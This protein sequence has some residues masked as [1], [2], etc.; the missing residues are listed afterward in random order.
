VPLIWLGFSA[1]QL[2]T[3]KRNLVLM[4]FLIFTAAP[5]HRGISQQTHHLPLSVIA[6]TNT[7]CTRR[8]MEDRHRLHGSQMVPYSLCSSLLLVLQKK[9]TRSVEAGEG[10]TA[11]NNGWNGV[12]GVVSNT[13]L[14]PFH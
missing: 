10:K 5:E 7:Q 8:V 4:G 1:T 12:N 6:L 14:I 11:H 9:C 3:G 2:N 13:W